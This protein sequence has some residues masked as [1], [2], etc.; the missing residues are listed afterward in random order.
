MASMDP[1]TI[2]ATMSTTAI[3]TG[4]THCGP[5]TRPPARPG[6]RWADRARRAL[7]AVIACT[8][9]LAHVPVRATE[10]I[11]CDSKG[12]GYN[13]CRVDTDGRVELVEK[14]GLFACNEGRSWGYDKHGVWVNKGCSAT[15][16]VGKDHGRRDAAIVAGVVG[17]AALAA[18]AGSRAQ[19][20]AAEVPAWAVGRFS[21]QDA[22]EGVEVRIEILPGGR[23]TGKA[24]SQEIAGQVS[25]QR[26]DAGRQS[27]RIERQGSGLLAVDVRDDTHRVNFR[28]LASGY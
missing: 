15:F 8:L 21:G 28:R 9:A 3:D 4:G 23:L 13:Y 2:G 7:A 27:F 6:G 18:I 22:R 16:R 11:R 25:G 1:D 12:F 17:L 20:D 24:G 5:R 14:H 10:T 19:H 26:M